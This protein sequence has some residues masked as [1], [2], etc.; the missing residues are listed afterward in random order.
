[1]AQQAAAEN[2]CGTAMCYTGFM[3]RS[4]WPPNATPS[5]QHTPSP[6]TKGNLACML[7]AHAAAAQAATFMLQS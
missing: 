6:K 4:A 5:H 7:L 2:M 3:Q 1:M